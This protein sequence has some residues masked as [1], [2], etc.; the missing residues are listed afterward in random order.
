MIFISDREVK[1]YRKRMYRHNSQ[2]NIWFVE[3]I[4]LLKLKE[5]VKLKKKWTKK[6]VWG[7][8]SNEN[9]EEPLN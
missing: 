1:I 2:K 5:E 8:F 3:Q 6:E 7:L 4:K 9:T